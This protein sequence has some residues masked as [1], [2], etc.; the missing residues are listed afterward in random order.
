MGY[1]NQIRTPFNLNSTLYYNAYIMIFLIGLNKL[2]VPLLRSYI[3]DLFALASLPLLT[4]NLSENIINAHSL[5][6]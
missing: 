1:Y 6:L 3:S 4:F 5:T 2:R